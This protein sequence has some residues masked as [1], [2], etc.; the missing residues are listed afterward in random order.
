ML[1]IQIQTHK[2]HLHA[3]EI[4]KTSSCGDFYLRFGSRSNSPTYI[5]SHNKIPLPND[6]TP[7]FALGV[8]DWDILVQVP[9]DPQTRFIYEKTQLHYSKNLSLRY[10]P[11]IA[12]VLAYEY[13]IFLYRD[14]VSTIERVLLRPKETEI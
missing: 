9:C 13:S 7:L 1:Q 10:R 11:D 3:F 4:P 5:F 12:L 2:N 6:S 8:E 14:Y